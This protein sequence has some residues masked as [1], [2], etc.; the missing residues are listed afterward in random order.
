MNAG[1]ASSATGLQDETVVLIRHEKRPSKIEGLTVSD[2]ECIPSSSRSLYAL[3]EFQLNLVNVAEFVLQDF[4]LETESLPKL[5][6]LLTSTPPFDRL[7]TPKEMQ[8]AKEIKK[9]LISHVAG[10]FCVARGVTFR[11]AEAIVRKEFKAAETTLRND[12]RWDTIQTVVQHNDQKYVCSMVPAGQMKLGSADIFE[13]SY[14]DKGV[15]SSSTKTAE[16]AANLWVSEIA[17]ADES[18]ETKEL[19]KGVR[20]G[21]LSVYGLN[22]DDPARRQGTLARA[23]EVVTAAL[24]TQPDVLKSALAGNEVSLNIV[25]TSLMT[26]SQFYNENEMLKD[27]MQAWQT[28]TQ[29]SPTCLAIRGEDGEIVQVKV[30]LNIVAFNFGVN[31]MAL[32]LGLGWSVSD[33]VNARAVEQ[34]LGKDFSSTSSPGGMVGDYLRDDPDN[35][36][37]VLTLCRHLKQI[38]AENSHHHDGGD[39]YKAALRIVILAY[40]IG[41]VPLSNCKSGKDRTGMLDAEIKREVISLHQGHPLSEPG[42]PLGA[43]NKAIF[44]QVL[45]NG[46]NSGVQSYNMGVEGNKVLVNRTLSS[47]NLSCEERIGNRAVFDEAQGLSRLVVS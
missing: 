41:A 6:F 31:T 26:P 25:S 36:A 34:L 37:K 14:G 24:F 32:K 33:K 40:E 38:F 18:G 10:K 8:A 47:L 44:Q 15:C 35:K 5:P 39:P 4:Q 27:Q 3:K 1:Q 29:Q 19:Y 20:H 28:L 23:R 9:Q 43:V 16:H 30:N 12:A 13:I 45:I 11:E 17:I 2:R 7:A 21:T 42:S 46:G 22:T